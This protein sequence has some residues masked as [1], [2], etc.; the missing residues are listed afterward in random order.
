MVTR[1]SLAQLGIKWRLDMC[2]NTLSFKAWIC[3]AKEF[4]TVH[5]CQAGVTVSAAGGGPH[6]D[7]YCYCC[8]LVKSFTVT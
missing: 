1:R 3:L 2:D 7:C 4:N 8:I 5:I 6:T